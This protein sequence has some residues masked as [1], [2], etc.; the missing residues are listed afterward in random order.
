MAARTKALQTANRQVDKAIHTP[1]TDIY[2]TDEAVVVVADLPG[3]AVEDLDVTVEN[4]RLRISGVLG[5]D[6]PRSGEFECKFA[7][8]D[9]LDGEAIDAEFRNGVVAVTVPKV[10]EARARKIAIKS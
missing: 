10:Q 6:A 5:E 2:E 7:L 4:D 1:R 8:S 9:R 3:V